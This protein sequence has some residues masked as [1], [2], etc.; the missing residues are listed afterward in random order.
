MQLTFL[1][2]EHRVRISASDMQPDQGLR[3]R[4]WMEAVLR[5][6]SDL[7]I[8]SSGSPQAGLFG[9]MSPMP[10]QHG[11]PEGW[12]G[13]SPAL[14]TS[15]IHALGGFWTRKTSAPMT[16]PDPVL[17]WSDIVTQDA[18]PRYFLS[19]RAIAGIA[20][21]ERKPRLFSPQEG[22]WLSTTERHAFWIEAARE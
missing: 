20:R 21:R 2:E 9:K 6:P 18:P 13:S 17:S 8:L 1:S 4:E 10:Y 16:S 5:S 12:V 14:G 7:S 3:G 15:G 22:A 19:R 11:I